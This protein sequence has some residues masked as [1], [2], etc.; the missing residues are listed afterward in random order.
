MNTI[1][2]A[3]LFGFLTLMTLGI[4]ILGALAV[5]VPPP[6]INLVAPAD[7]DPDRVLLRPRQVV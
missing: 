7:V 2:L 6:I 5:T 1:I 4:F 3:T